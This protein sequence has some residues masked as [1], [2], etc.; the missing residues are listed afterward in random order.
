[1]KYIFISDY[2]VGGSLFC[3]MWGLIDLKNEHNKKKWSHSRSC[4]DFCFVVLLK[5]KRRVPLRMRRGGAGVKGRGA[6]TGLT[7][8]KFNSVNCWSLIK[9]ISIQPYG[10]NQAVPKR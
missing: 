4:K 8:L 2:P 10:L 5:L 6:T 1:M 7:K 9:L 3:F